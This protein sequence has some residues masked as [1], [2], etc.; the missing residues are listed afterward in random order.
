MTRLVRELALWTGA[1]LGLIAVA[2]GVAVMFFGFNFLIF[3]SGSM[4]PDIPT[5]GLALSRSVA[6]DDLA[7]GDV[8]SVIAAS[9]ERL[10]H[11]VVSSTVREGE[12]SLVLQ[13]DANAAPDAEVYV[14]RS[15]DRV[16]ASVPW[17]GFVLA[18]ALTPPGLVA[19][20]SLGL[21]LV[22]VGF[23]GGRDSDRAG[24]HPVARRSSRR[25]RHRAAGRE[26]SLM[27]VA[28]SL[29][30]VIAFVTAA[31]LGTVHTLARFTDAPAAT[32]GQF[33]AMSVQPPSLSC[34]SSTSSLTISWP[35]TSNLSYTASISGPSGTASLSI[36]TS[37]TTRS[38][39]IT[40]SEAPADRNS[41][42]NYTVTVVART[43]AST[44]WSSLAQQA[45]STTRAD[46]S[47]KNNE[48]LA[49]GSA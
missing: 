12:A 32:T 24:V 48:T 49:C 26:R 1:L 19:V 34:V 22:I 47:G 2:A 46:N 27:G 3:R 15:A 33:S 29:L 9:G 23:T 43:G 40:A 8:V 4:E 5:G 20:G 21:M 42:V 6:A 31:G 16:V 37:G 13:G 38:V 28:T 45:T 39:R 30:L 25:P 44:G 11:R 7:I 18:H 35:A 10:T 17:G 14:V 41:T 36:A